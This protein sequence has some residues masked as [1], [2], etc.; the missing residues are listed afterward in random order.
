M[1]KKTIDMRWVASHYAE[2]YMPL[3][4]AQTSPPGGSGVG[5]QWANITRGGGG[6]LYH[7]MQ[8]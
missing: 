6:E 2:S 3:F 1:P 4:D 7:K 8:N 5:C